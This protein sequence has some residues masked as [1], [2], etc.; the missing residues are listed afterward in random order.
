MK[1]AKSTEPKK[2]TS[3]LPPI[4]L[5][6]TSFL[7]KNP[8]ETGR[9]S[10]KRREKLGRSKLL[11]ACT[12]CPTPCSTPETSYR[13]PHDQP[14]SIPDGPISPRKQKDVTH[15]DRV[16]VKHTHYDMTLR[17]ASDQTEDGLYSDAQTDVVR[18]DRGADA[19]PT[20]LVIA[21]TVAPLTASGLE[22][23]QRPDHSPSVAGIPTSCVRTADDV[24]R[25]VGGKPS[26]AGP[27]NGHPRDRSPFREMRSVKEIK[28]VYAQT[29][30]KLTTDWNSPVATTMQWSR[31][32]H[33]SISLAPI[34][35]GSPMSAKARGR[36]RREKVT[37]PRKGHRRVDS[38]IGTLKKIV[39]SR[40]DSDALDMSMR[41][42]SIGLTS[43]STVRESNWT[44]NLMSST[45]EDDPVYRHQQ[46]AL[47]IHP[48]LRAAGNL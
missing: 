27:A 41:R 48:S 24:R 44:S 43:Q 36:L 28:S 13:P 18:K 25:E 22:V 8:V 12:L 47:S 15:R 39:R 34:I 11:V 6:F 14:A 31:R 35:H 5:G 17:P 16:T 26:P 45:L 20:D 40:S 21:A 33:R 30:G 46:S 1:A 42:L 23:Q 29:E 32:K 37:S 10:R 19:I 7:D 38:Q 3:H 4:H 2:T 9:Q